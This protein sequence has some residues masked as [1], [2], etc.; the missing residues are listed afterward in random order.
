MATYAAALDDALGTF[1][2]TGA[3]AELPRL[4]SELAHRGLDAG[5]EDKALTALVDLLSNDG[6]S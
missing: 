6:A 1:R 4:F 5:L 2:E 3:P